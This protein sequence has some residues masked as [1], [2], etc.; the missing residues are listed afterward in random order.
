MTELLNT[1][2][3]PPITDDPD[4]A[5]THLVEHGVCRLEGALPASRLDV[6]RREVK[7][8]AIADAT[9]DR[10]YTYSHGTN[11]RIWSLFNRGECFLDLAEDPSALRVV[12]SVLGQ[13]ALV[14]NLSANVTRPGGAAMAP[15]WDQDWAERPWPHAFVA[16]VIWMIDDFTEDNGA[17]LV[18]PGSHRLDG[19]PQGDC[20]VPATGAAGTALVI[21]GRTWH[22]T[23][24]NVTVDVQRVGILA[25]YCRPYIRQQENMALS[26]SDAVRDSMSPERRKFYGLEFWEYLNMAGGPPQELPRF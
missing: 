5:S 26:L 15:H 18:C 17:T 13:D 16:H 1:S 23:G 4:E 7:A 2:S 20:M 12:R 3:L 25:Y 24:R 6:L 21:D 14:S 10:S 11:Y 9:A 8:A 22:G 19:T